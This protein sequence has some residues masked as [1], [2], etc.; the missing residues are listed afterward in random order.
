M[1][2]KLPI[3]VV[4]D[5]A[6]LRTGLCDLLAFRGYA[7]TAAGTGDE[8]L[9]LAL[10]GRFALVLLDVML[11]GLSGLDV[12][13]ELRAARPEQA[14]LMLT[15][16]GAE[17]DVLEG[18]RRGADD[19]VTKPFS[20]SE[21]MARVEALLRRAGRL[22]RGDLAP[23]MLDRWRVD[24]AARS[25]TNGKQAIELTRRELEMLALFARER[26]RI[27][28]RRT[29]LLE[30]WGMSHVEKIRTRTVD[31]HVAKLRK[32]LGLAESGPLETVRGEGYR[33]A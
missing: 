18:F 31:V 33:F 12:C 19:Y 17:E 27:V 20:V 3:L 4:E 7:P 2:T 10:G 15:A 23:F 14:I 8:G 26:G 32:K 5:E 29:L 9:R 30:V 13:S 28:S 6:S 25:A 1:E 21:L 16:R 22:P 24:P 11:P